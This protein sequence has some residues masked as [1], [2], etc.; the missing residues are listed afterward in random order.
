[1]IVSHKHKFIFVK[2]KKTAGSTLEALLYPYLGQEDYCT[3]STR[4]GTP[5][6]NT[7][8]DTNGHL[9]WQGIRHVFP[10]AWNDYFKFT[11]ERNPW[12]KCVSS[13]YWHQKIKPDQFAN[14]PFEDYIMTC[15]MLPVDWLNYAQGDMIAVDKVYKYEE[16]W[17]MY[18][19]LNERFGFD[20]KQEQTYNT[21]MKAGIRKN[22][23]Y[24]TMYN[25][26]T[27]ARVAELFKHEIDLLGYSYE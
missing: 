3:G 22:D 12:D 17:E 24:R 26:K 25:D 20:I 1:M 2:T 23:D 7:P 4:D 18:S 27:I 21:R 10:E 13:Y 16:M 19:D 14:M 6:L 9:T 15:T 8:P 5:P 11:I